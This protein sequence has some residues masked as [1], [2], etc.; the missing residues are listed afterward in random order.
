MR[1]LIRNLGAIA[2]GD[3]GAPFAE[4]DE[5]LIE[6]G[7]IAAVGRELGAGAGAGADQVFDARGGVL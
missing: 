5:I 4:G 7:R 3:V 1:T 2:C 6:D